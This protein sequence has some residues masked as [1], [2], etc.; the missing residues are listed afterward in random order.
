M[1][2]HVGERF[3]GSGPAGQPG[4]YVVTGVV[5]ETPWSGLY[6][7]K[8]IFYNFDFTDKEPRETEEK[9]WLDIYLRTVQYPE[10]DDPVYV[11]GRRAM[12]R[13]E[14]RRVLGSSASHVW[15]EP[16]DLL[17]V[18]NT[19]D[20]FSLSGTP[21]VGRSATVDPRE[22][23]G[24]FA[25][26][27]GELLG[28]WRRARP[29]QSA[30]LAVLGELLGFLRA[31]HEEGLVVNG[32]G[33]DTVLVDHACRIH[34][35]GSD[36]TAD[37]KSSFPWGRFF[38]PERYATG[39]AAPE[40]F[41]AAVPRSARTD[42]F[43]WAVLAWFLLTGADPAELAAKQEQLWVRFRTEELSALEKALRAVAPAEINA[44]ADQLGQKGEALVSHWPRG[45]LT[46]FRQCVAAD[47]RQRPP[48]VAALL[49][50]LVAPPPAPVA[51]VLA[52]R[53]PGDQVRL[54]FDLAGIDPETQL[55]IR[56]GIGSQPLTITEGEP[57]SSGPPRAWLDDTPPRR[58]APEAIFYGVFTR[59][60]LQEEAPSSA[61]VPAQLLEPTAANLR[62]FA[63]SAATGD[64]R[65]PPA[66]SLLFQALDAVKVAEA[67]LVSSQARVRSWAA[68]HLGSLMQAGRLAAQAETLLWRSLA[69]S[70]Q[71]VRLQAA[72][73]LLGPG[74]APDGRRV[75]R[76]L[77]LL[78]GGNLD[79]A[80]E[81]ARMLPALGVSLDLIR[82]VAADLEAERPAAC[83]VCGQPVATRDRAEHLRAAHGYVDVS[84]N[85]LSRPAALERLWDRV[86]LGNDAPAHDQV[87]DILDRGPS[88]DREDAPYAA[89]LRSQLGA[90]AEALLRTRSQEVP[91]LVR[92]LRQNPRAHPYFPILLRDADPN[93]REVG[94]EL[95][96]PELGGRLGAGAVTA[97][98]IR[99]ELDRVC[100]ADEL[101]EKILLCRQLPYLGIDAAVVKTCLARLENE[102]L[103]V[104]PECARMIPGGQ[105]ESHLRR[106]HRVF[107]FR[108]ERRPLA[109][110]GS[111][112]LEAVCGPSPDPEAWAVL[113]TI[114]RDEH[115]DKSACLLASWLAQKL[116]AVVDEQRQQ[117][118]CAVAEAVAAGESGPRMVN[119]LAAAPADAAFRPAALHL[120]LEVTA[121]LP[122]PVPGN[123]LQAVKPLVGDKQAP[124]EARRAALGALLPS[125]GTTGP[126]VRELL[127][128][129]TAGTGKEASIRRLRQ[130]QQEVGRLDVIDDLCRELEDQVRMRCTRCPAE[131]PRVQMVRH[132]WEEHR[133]VL[134][135]RRVREPWRL[136]EDWL[137]DYRLERD[138]Q[139][140]A[141]CEELAGRLDPKQGPAHL[142]RLLLQHGVED[143]EAR[144][145]LLAQARQQRASL[146]PHCY[147]QVPV[148]DALPPASVDAGAGELEAMG[149]GVHVA[150]RWLLPWLTIHTPEGVLRDG[151]QSGWFRT[152]AGM[153]AF[154][155]G[156][157]ILVMFGL[158][159]FVSLPVLLGITAAAGL[160]VGGLAWLTWPTPPPLRDR[161]VNAAW[162]ILV[163][164]MLDRL[165]RQASAFLAGLAWVSANRGTRH[166]R[167]EVLDEACRV[168][169]E[170]S[171]DD[172][173]RARHL[174]ALL[175]LQFEDV[176]P[177]R[178][179]VMPLLLE[180]AERC[181]AGKSPLALLDELLA[182]S[183]S[184]W[185]RPALQARFRTLL[186][187][188]AFERGLECSDLLD[189]GRA[190]PAL[191]AVL[192]VDE[193]GAL[194]QLRLLWWLRQARPW[195]RLGEARTVF[196][197][198]D[199]PRFG[200][201]S[202][203]QC[204]D[205][206]VALE[207]T[208]SLFI[209]TRGV[210]LD[211]TCITEFVESVEIVSQP[212]P[213]Q[214]FQLVVGPHS[215]RL[216]DNPE[217]V[218]RVLERTLRY[219]FGDF[220][221]Q[222]PSALRWRS[223]GVL[224]QLGACNGAKC[225]G[226][227]RR[228]LPCLGDVA[229]S[230]EE[231]ERTRQA[232]L[233]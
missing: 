128:A 214:R 59:W 19:R 1:K 100:P 25:R 58:P 75:R 116:S 204:P 230:L 114:T 78:G 27:Q 160:I 190:L 18:P 172:P 144:T 157:M 73:G 152:H 169:K 194:A 219:Y 186:C 13:G 164:K 180:Q 226:C 54:F 70:S 60:L 205:L 167:A 42:L 208:P 76:V 195:N 79:Q 67:L 71:T 44:W 142:Q 11:A 16:V 224:A 101:E 213:P 4:G 49:S 179:D 216:R 83:P 171:A 20:A 56:R 126:A 37:A 82:Q 66:V 53:R 154:I 38:P 198:A 84:G 117:V 15:P 50:W 173:Q 220:L 212:G 63:E 211:G 139:L 85:L 178:A 121:R 80:L 127:M 133:L 229:I 72:A 168:L 143:A 3:A 187:M 112:L 200:L 185:G 153:A 6:L 96:L 61:P 232:A 99:R 129:F 192:K 122:A 140:M 8:K 65:E 210:W 225:P 28:H 165:T 68:R 5:R 46:T 119:Q 184:P 118:A 130:L 217:D 147:S 51:A 24:I 47:P 57:V 109:E 215:F 86:F 132:L 110:A 9:E 64:D 207:M 2:L 12:A 206:L 176:A 221:P 233:G 23:V 174:G 62:L 43:A 36:M 137:E 170:A 150:D 151:F 94:R 227:R 181:L 145:T 26:P 131:L 34:F 88:R 163:P 22:P 158:M 182:G 146:C 14:I 149:Y 92:C 90:R 222:A 155:G 45:F 52:L 202:L 81:A 103:V 191:G 162:T 106:S 21:S 141:R 199:N 196:E 102:R 39:F 138:P 104:C 135:G 177:R 108:G 161:A 183:K 175:R 7:G 32:L 95:L 228:I 17:E 115:P 105:V 89:A 77:E 31:A 123:V 30:V 87:L 136:I 166:D 189:L 197:L 201:K 29:S 41:D 193:P 134:E 120:A 124:A 159:V 93:I 40:C 98:D 111:V 125:V 148:Q 69:D 33:P 113:E 231:Q 35:L 74:S 97:R 156:F 91:R 188:A 107:Q 218:A 203:E 209:G 48:S 223:P 55:V 10:L